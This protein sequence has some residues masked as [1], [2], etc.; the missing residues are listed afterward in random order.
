[1]S[2]VHHVYVGAVRSPDGGKGGVFR[3]AAGSQRWDALSDG[4]PTGAEVHAITVHPDDT[5]IV[6]AA[7][8][9]GA[10]RS[11]GRGD[12]WER[13]ALP[14]QGVDVWSITVHPTDRRTL[15][16]GYGPT[17]VFRSDDGGDSWQ[18]LA[19]P[20]LPDR[21]RMTFPCR[22]MRL[23]VDPGTPDGVYA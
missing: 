14:D 20:K 3:Q 5:D 8:T 1:M 12:K 13:M 15:Y 23:D 2:T 17:G 9:K 21:V 7:T 6:F 11:T 18:K 22:V 19:A 4:M 16:A 10:F